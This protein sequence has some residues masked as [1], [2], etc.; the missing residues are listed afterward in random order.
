MGS[1]TDTGWFTDG[2]ALSSYLM[3]TRA[4]DTRMV[5]SVADA[6]ARIDGWRSGA[7]TGPWNGLNRTAVA[8]R[9]AQ[10][11]ADPR[12]VRQGNLNLCGPASLVCMWAAR[13][14]HSFASLGTT[15]FDYGSAYLGSLLLQPSAELLQADSST[16]SGSTYGADWMVLGA[17]RNSTN[18]FWQGSWRG[19]P[20]KELAG[21]TR[22]EELAEWLTAVGIYAVVLNEAN[23]VT[24]AGIPHATGL[25][26]AEGRDIALLLHVNL[27]NAARHVPLDQSFLLNQ[28]PNHY[29]V[30]LNSPTLAVGDDPGGSY[31]DGDVLLSLW[32][33]GE[34]GGHLSLAVPQ[35]EFVANYY[36]A[37][38]ADL[39]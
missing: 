15:L 2:D 8:D 5:S 7:A 11:V 12:L 24:P 17:I 9:L 38:V 39:A 29:V 3:D 34:V 14:P 30:A 32:T 36:G 33:W 21:L 6:V 1:P 18:V 19:D 16:F 31:V 20:A 4:S 10:I 35:A 28:F 27:I 37:V 23:W 25:E 13:D 26:F 22:P